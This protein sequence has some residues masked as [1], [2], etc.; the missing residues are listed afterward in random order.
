MLSFQRKLEPPKS[1]EIPSQA[2][3]NTSDLE[4]SAYALAGAL[5]P[6]VPSKILRSTRD[7]RALAGKI[8]DLAETQRRKNIN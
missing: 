2:F 8:K 4:L 5:E 3:P 7:T 1:H 6:R